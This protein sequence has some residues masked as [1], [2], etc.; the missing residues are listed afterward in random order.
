VTADGF[1]IALTYGPNVDWCRNL[2]AAGGGTVF[3]HGTAYAAGKPEPIAS[4]AVLPILPPLFRL[5]LS[6]TGV[7][8]FVRVHAA[9]ESPIEKDPERAAR[10]LSSRQ[11]VPAFSEK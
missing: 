3:W 6:T 9:R 11:R 7:H 1:V 4:K 2:V 10:G 5:A 8:D